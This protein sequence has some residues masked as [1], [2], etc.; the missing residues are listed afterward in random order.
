ML[1]LFFAFHDPTTLNAQGPDR[2]TQYRSIILTNS[3]EQAA[4][5]REVMAE[6]TRDDAFGQPIV[7]EIKP[8]DT[9]WPGE[10]SHQQYFQ[11]HPR[12]HIAPR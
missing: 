9:F 2:G 8:L 7:T 11:R 4:I 12:S 10:L 5:A 6:L 3:A 1:E